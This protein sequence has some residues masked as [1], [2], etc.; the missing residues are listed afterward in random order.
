MTAALRWKEDCC[1]VSGRTVTKSGQGSAPFQYTDLLNDY[2]DKLS[3]VSEQKAW[4]HVCYVERWQLKT[5][6]GG[7]NCFKFHTTRQ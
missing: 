5:R 4:L 6:A 1:V 2:I 3:S 7:D